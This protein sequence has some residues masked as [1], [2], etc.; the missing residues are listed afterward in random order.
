MCLVKYIITKDA[1]REDWNC[2]FTYV[3]TVLSKMSA[4]TAITQMIGLVLRQPHARLTQKPSLDEC[5]VYTFN[6]DL[7][8]AVDRCKSKPL[9]SFVGVN[10]N[11]RCLAW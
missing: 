1:L 2:P 9:A 5:Y 10:A 7:M 11:V 3:L 4:K 8:E 6:Q